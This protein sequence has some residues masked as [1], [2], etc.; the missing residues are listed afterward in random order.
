MDVSEFEVDSSGTLTVADFPE[1]EVR[2]EFY[3]S[4]ASFWSKS[5]SSLVEAMEE[6]EPLAWAVQSI[7]EEQQDE[8][9]EGNTEETTDWVLGLSAK[10]FKEQVVP[11]IREWFDSPPDWDYEDDYLPKE[12]TAQGAAM[13]FFES[14]DGETLD[15]LGVEIVE[16]EHPGSTYYA[17]ELTVPIGQANKAAAAAGIPVRFTKR[18]KQKR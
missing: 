12:A 9:Q 3:E 13:E 10:A 5:P 7:Y 4:V 1:P 16:G 2:S 15:I 17:A 6:C 18:K 8:N 11:E 14:M